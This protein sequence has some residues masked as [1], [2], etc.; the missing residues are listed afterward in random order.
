MVLPPPNVTGSLH[1]GHALTVALQDALVRWSVGLGG[2]E[3]GIGGWGGS[4]GGHL[5]LGGA[6]WGIWGWGG[7]LGHLGRGHIGCFVGGSWGAIGV[8]G[9]KLGSP[10][11]IWGGLRGYLGLGGCLVGYFGGSFGPSRTDLGVLE[12]LQ[13]VEAPLGALGIWGGVSSM[14]A[15]GAGGCSE[16]PT[17][18]WVPTA[19]CQA[20]DAGLERALGTGHRPCR[21]RHPGET[22]VP[23]SLP[24]P[25]PVSPASPPT[26][27]QRPPSVCP[28]AVVERWLWQQRGLRR[29]DLTRSEFLEEVWAWKQR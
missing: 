27:P 6:V 20:A 14:G 16:Y 1:L 15:G 8:W 18:V 26:C 10:G 28:Q 3:W 13:G 12:A 21:H 24:L 7:C 19:L 11:G 9:G 29:Q 23:N 25:R 22:R 2:A 4:L 5:G 17:P